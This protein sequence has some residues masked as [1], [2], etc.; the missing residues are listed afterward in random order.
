MKLVT[1]VPKS[2]KGKNLVGR[3]GTKWVVLRHEVF[4]PCCN[5]EGMLVEPFIRRADHDDSRW[6]GMM[7]DKDFLVRE[8]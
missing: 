1:L 2:N 5:G 7:N 4:V 8:L 3:F 6:V